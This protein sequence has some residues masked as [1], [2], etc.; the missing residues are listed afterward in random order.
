M[1]IGI[2]SYGKTVLTLRSCLKKCFHE[3]LMPNADFV[4]LMRTHIGFADHYVVQHAPRALCSRCKPHLAGEAG[5]QMTCIA[6]ANEKNQLHFDTQ[7]LLFTCFRE[8]MTE[9]EIIEVL[10][11]PPYHGYL[12]S[13]NRAD[14]LLRMQNGSV[15]YLDVTT[16]ETAVRLARMSLSYIVNDGVQAV[17]KQVGWEGKKQKYAAC[18]RKF[19]GV[20][21]DDDVIPI[22]FDSNGT[23][24]RESAAWLKKTMSAKTWKRFSREVSEIFQRYHGQRLRVVSQRWSSQSKLGSAVPRGGTAEPQRGNGTDAAIGHRASH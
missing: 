20:E 15:V 10:W 22:V 1:S 18:R 14:I 3:N 17:L 23:I 19:G 16:V 7:R 11:E 24:F 2:G 8:M 12:G 13:E 5:H 9:G 6:G 21:A 4:A